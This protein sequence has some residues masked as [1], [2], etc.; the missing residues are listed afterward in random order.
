MRLAQKYKPKKLIEVVGQP[1]ALSQ[2][3]L[4]FETWERGKPL[5]IHGP[6]GTGKTATVHALAAEKG[7]EIVELSSEEVNL[8]RIL[9]SIK[10]HSLLRKPKLVLVDGADRM[11]TKL[12][13]K[14]IKE[15]IFPVILF[16]DDVWKSKFKMLRSGSTIIQFKKIHTTIIEKKLQEIKQCENLSP[17]LDPYTFAKAAEGDMRAALI[18]I[19]AGT[20]AARDR[21]TNIFDVLKAVFKENYE[22]AKIAIENSDK[23]PQQ[24]LWWI[25]ENIQNEFK[26]PK[27]LAAA[28]ELLSRADLNKRKTLSILAGLS[29]VHKHRPEKFTAYKPPKFKPLT[30][31]E[32]C[33]KLAAAMHCSI[34]TARKELPYLKKILN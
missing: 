7:L 30:D 15:S 12:L 28:F 4:W 34:S 16:I 20:D 14:I 1:Q 23:D 31:S 25:E 13:N 6:P 32:L 26:E 27:E 19:D 33:E 22:K 17:N 9:P 5:I 24:V 29:S 21:T 10:Q 8:E 2:M 3:L 18:D 11:P